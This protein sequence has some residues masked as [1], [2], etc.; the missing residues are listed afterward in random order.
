MDYAGDGVGLY[1]TEYSYL[2]RTELPTEQELVEEYRDLASILYPRRVVIRTLDAGGDK[3][4]HGFEQLEESNP[5]LGLRAVRFCLRHQD[6]FKTQ[7]RAILRA[8]VHGNV[9]P[10]RPS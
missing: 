5:V 9:R 8:A 10:D 2:Y 6:I 1:R 3:L 4:G 7:L